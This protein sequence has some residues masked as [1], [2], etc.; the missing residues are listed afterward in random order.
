MIRRPV[1]LLLVF[2]LTL[3]SVTPARAQ[4]G[5][6]ATK[7]DRTLFWTILGA[8]AGAGLGFLIGYDLDEATHTEHY[9]VTS[10]LVGG[11]IGAGVGFAFGRYRARLTPG[12]YVQV[13]EALTAATLTEGIRVS[14][15]MFTANDLVGACRETRPV[16]RLEIIP[17]AIDL[18]VDGRYPLNRISIVAVNTEGV[19]VV[20]GV[21]IVLETQ[22][23]SPP[24]VQLRSDDP[25]INA[26]V[27]HVVRPG[28]F[29]LR[30]RTICGVPFAEATVY[31]TVK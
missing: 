24:I 26:G 7:P 2:F 27:L 22:D 13:A 28:N 29:R 30:A 10:T 1:G 5:T 23:T 17:A 15:R 3:G 25:D 31:G 12:Y 4:Q 6:T 19:A 9:S 8:A 18:P 16:A 20:P 14:S 11:A 21:P